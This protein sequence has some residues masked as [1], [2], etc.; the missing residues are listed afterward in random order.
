MRAL[1]AAELL[2]VWE[3]GLGSPPAA[4]VLVLLAAA[5][6][7]VP[8]SSLPQLAVGERDALLLTLREW[9][10][11][12]QLES[13]VSCPQCD[14]PLELSFAVDNIRAVPAVTDA[15][16][17]GQ[18]SR[19][20]L[21]IE[22][23]ELQFR[24]P[25]VADANAATSPEQ[26]LE[27]CLLAANCDGEAQ[28]ASDLP[29]DVIEALSHHIAAADP[30]ADVQLALDCPACDHNWL[31]TFDVASFLWEEIGT[32]AQR[33]LLEVH[34][35]ARAYGWSEADILA[36]SPLRRQVYLTMVGAT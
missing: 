10:F 24:V 15:A 18:P 5:C 23:C 31:A 30:Q 33:T 2:G 4:G 36:M 16:A 7:E 27:S 20:S 19:L 14:E 32:W 13:V 1:S 34:Q 26:L 3:Q 35:L 11:G 29:E 9:L 25:T 22:G 12:S 21:E 17:L 6:P 28:A 8:A